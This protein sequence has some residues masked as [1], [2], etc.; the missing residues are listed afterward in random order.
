MNTILTIIKKEFI[1]TIRDRRTLFFM[2]LIPLLLIPVM[3]GIFMKISMSFAKKAKEKTIT[4]ALITNG[5]A[6]EFAQKLSALDDFKIIADI[7]VDSVQSFILKDSID[8]ALILAEDFDAKIKTHEAGGISMYYRSTVD[9]NITRR[10]LRT[11]VDDF[12]DELL[13]KRLAELNLDESIVETLDLTQIDVAS[14]KEKVGKLIGGML[15]YMF[16]IFCFMGAMYPAIDLAAGEKERGT[17]E[18]LLASPASRFQ[19][20]L[21]KFTI[22][23][24]A[25]FTSAAL[26][27]LGIYIGIRQIGEIPPEFLNAILGLLETKS[28]VMVLSLLLPLTA[29]FAAVMLGL[30][31]F[32]K[33]FKEAQ[34]IITPLNFM[35]IIP[36]AIGLLP[37]IELNFTTALIPILNIS[38]ATKT[39][40]AGT[41]Q[42]EYLVVVYA[43]LFLLAGVSLWACSK[44]FGREQTIFRM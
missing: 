2:V 17:L 21:G 38:L 41:I 30:S 26:S 33:S 1:D 12:R 13:K 8:A 9:E 43:S 4:L 35:V 24:F 14:T 18:T 31:I 11:L 22:V 10:R 40:L 5:N 36:A 39:I 29:F 6:E 42:V 28:I 7:Q 37:G 23:S 3:M 34:S 32:A 25:G 19:I 27:I 15:P 44:W 20:L 16:V